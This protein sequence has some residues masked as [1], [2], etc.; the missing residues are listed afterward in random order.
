MSKFSV[1]RPFTVLVA[2]IVVLVFG[3]MSY[4]K[5]VPDLL[6]NMDFPY[7]VVV[8]TYPGATPEE[9]ENQ[10]TRPLEQSMATLNNIKTLQSSSSANYCTIMLEF[11]QDTNMDSATVDILQKIQQL[12][13]S[14]DEGIGTPTITRINPS[15]LPVMVAAVESDEMDRYELCQFTEETLLR[16]LEGTTGL[17]SVSAGGVLERTLTIALNDAKIDK[18]N[19]RVEEALID[20]LEEARQKLEDAQ[21][22]IDDATAQ[23]NYG[24]YQL[25]Q[26]PS[27]LMNSVNTGDMSSTLEDYANLTTQISAAE[28]QRS[29]LE[30]EKQLYEENL[31]QVR[32]SLAA[33]EGQLADIQASRA[34]LAV[35]LNGN[36]ALPDDSSLADLGLDEGSLSALQA[37]GCYTLGDVRTKELNLAASELSLSVSVETARATVKEAEEAAN[38]RLPDLNNELNTVNTELAALQAQAKAHSDAI[39]KYQAGLDELPGQLA[40]G[41]VQITLAGGQLAAAQSG[42]ASAQSSLDQALETYETQ[43]EA[44]LKAADL[45]GILTLETLSGLITAQNF[46]MPAGYVYEEDIGLVVSVGNGLQSVEE[47]RQLPLLDL[48]IEGLEPI[49]IAD[50]ADIVITD[51]A[52]EIYATLDGNDG[53][54]LMFSKQSNYATASVC[55]N[56]NESFAELSEKYPG[57]HFVP[58]MDQGDYIY[59][60]RDS[61]LSSLLWG[62]LFS[63]LILFVFLRDWRPTVITLLSIPVSLLFAMTL[64]YFS[65][66][67]IN[68]MSLSGLAISVGMLVDNSIVVIENTYRLR[69]LGESPIKA[70]VSGARQVGG[71]VAASTLTTVCVFAPIAF[72]EGLTRQLF[73]DMILTLSFALLASLVVALTV[74]PALAGKLLRQE[75]EHGNG[76]LNRLTP[77]YRRSVNWAVGHKAIVILCCAALL[78]SSCTLL[79]NR[80][81]NFMPEMEMEQLGATLTM[82]E[83]S[84]F[85]ELCAQADEATARIMAINGVATVGA[86]ADDD[87]ITYYIITD[88]E[89][90]RR[91]GE[92]AEE[93]NAVCADMPC[94]V[95]ADPN[96]MMVSRMA[97]L[98]GSGV[99]MRLYGSDLN[100]L[101]AAADSIA[102][103]LSEMEGIEEVSAGGEEAARELH[104]V[105][106]KDA[107][108]AE[109]L[110][111]AQVYM[112]VATALTGN[113]ELLT[114]ADNRIH[115]DV[116]VE[117]ESS[118]TLTPEFLENFSFTVTDKMGEEHTVALADLAT[119]E[120]LRTP[121]TINRLEQRRYL[122][123]TAAIAEG[124]NVT[125]VT[126]E[127]EAVLAALTLPESVELVFSGE[128]ES[129]MDA[130]GDLLLLMLIGILLVYLVMVAQ[131]QNLKSPFIVMFTIPL[132]FTGAFLALLISGDELNVV[133]MLG[134]IM[135]VGIIVNNGIVL[136]DYINQLRLS[137]KERRE[138]IVEAAVTRLRPILMTTITTVLGLTVMA[139]GQ[140][141]ATS[142]IQPLAVSCIGGLCYAT[143]MTLYVVPVMYDTFSKKELYSV[144]EDDLEL[145][146]L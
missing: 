145:S 51:N 78:L 62:A 86:T 131:F 119:L 123:V 137:G 115:Y 101:Q 92:I 28:A 83:E 54:L 108:T 127:V 97:M 116:I 18:T 35:A 72:V 13:G 21:K 68:I 70:A 96:S 122:D 134:L 113:T 42:L 74:V 26:L 81:F 10:V 135:L 30:A 60:L 77:A 36:E 138:A 66:V 69:S 132:A 15:M 61:I 85:E 73:T 84:S 38:L 49:R 71:A 19:G 94:T 102:E 33:L 87:A 5:M 52:A 125:R 3:I 48:G 89:S 103:T 120:E 90:G 109:G 110:T 118:E 124:Y 80:G 142:I 12:T 107:A 57:L 4:V 88:P 75:K 105:V 117:T 64:M 24:L 82:P 1:R 133:S 46:D 143:L 91:P 100:E 67:G 139:L 14:W 65:G 22:E 95:T 55:N 29:A 31:A 56:L 59:L 8:T 37:L 114:L 39:A 44:A 79:L 23:V 25:Q 53:L 129:I 63:V 106:D 34:L 93:I 40:G 17:A 140:N 9:V 121:A 43:L 50:V 128:R 146:E 104:F 76:L 136:V 7:I 99:T 112:E 111:V 130:M 41:V 58:L 45:H 144:A 6:P 98:S 126:D 32:G 11:E 20:S 2:V 27:T 47:L 16:E 141:E